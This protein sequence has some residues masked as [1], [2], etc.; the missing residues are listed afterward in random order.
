VKR[1]LS[2]LFL[3]VLGI[4]ISA[5]LASN[6]SGKSE[7]VTLTDENHVIF[8]GPVNDR[9]VAQAQLE[10]S[11]ISKEL[12]ED[13]IIYLVLDTP[14]GSVSAGN[15]F[16]DFAKSLPQKIKPIC[17][18]CASMGYHMFQS[19]EERLVYSSS[20]LMSH[21]AAL[22]G[23]SGQV[24]GELESRLASIKVVLNQMDAVAAKRVG[25]TKEAYQKLIYDELWLD[26]IS[27]VKT[28]HADRL[29]K[30]KCSKDLADATRQEEV[31]TLFGPVKI[32]LSKCP[33]I[34]G[35]LE[36]EFSR[37]KSQFRS[38]EEALS[39]VRKHKR[40]VSLEF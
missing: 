24:P 26:G 17:I 13:E 38:R 22:G 33:L 10:L 15:L 34:T 30:I 7:V 19:F 18:F 12:D 16:I 40:R 28:R 9:S 3:F 4:L 32:T 11:R 8:S 39:E 1:T 37:E 27:A 23:L 25:L 2:N 21:R 31:L 6:M 20:T 36:A 14:G 29:A 5:H 35:V